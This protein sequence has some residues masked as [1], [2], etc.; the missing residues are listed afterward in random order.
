MGEKRSNKRMK[1]ISFAKSNVYTAIMKDKNL[2]TNQ[3][4]LIDQPT[5]TVFDRKTD[6]A[7]GNLV[8]ISISGIMIVS[9]I[10]ITKK[11]VFQLRME[12]IQNIVFNATCVWTRDIG[13]D[14]YISGFEF[15]QIEP[16][17]ID[18]IKQTINQFLNED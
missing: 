18:I 5:F 11:A 7:I 8:D 16:K 6:K 10:P 15:I 3:K 2:T 13:A 1:L 17:E 9:E 12:F 14:Y 4:K